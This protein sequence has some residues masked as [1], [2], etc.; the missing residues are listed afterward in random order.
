MRKLIWIL[1]VLLGVLHYDFWYWDDPT[2]VA[3]FVPV[4]LAYQAG[5]SVA[6]GLLWAAAVFFAWPDELEEWADGTDQATAA[7]AGEGEVAR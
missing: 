1:V 4:G 6:C 2:L 5:Y 7:S 3:G